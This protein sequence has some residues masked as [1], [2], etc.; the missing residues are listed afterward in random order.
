M[1]IK[2]T[3]KQLAWQ[4]A[5]P[6]AE[7]FQKP[8]KVIVPLP[9]YKLKGST[10]FVGINQKT[11]N[12]LL[13]DIFERFPLGAAVLLEHPA[14]KNA[15]QSLGVNESLTQTPLNWEW[16][17]RMRR[18]AREHE[19]VRRIMGRSAVLEFEAELHNRDM[20]V[21]LQKLRE[22]YMERQIQNS[23]E[24]TRKI[25]TASMEERDRRLERVEYNHLIWDQRKWNMF[26]LRYLKE[27]SP[28][29]VFLKDRIDQAAEPSITQRVLDKRAEISPMEILLEITD[30]L[31]HESQR[32]QIQRT[33]EQWMAQI[34]MAKV[35]IADAA[36]FKKQVEKMFLQT[37]IRDYAKG[38]VA[39]SDEKASY[40][41]LQ[42]SRGFHLDKMVDNRRDS[43]EFHL[44]GHVAAGKDREAFVQFV[45]RLN[46]RRYVSNIYNDLR[47]NHQK[48]LANIRQ[49]YP[50]TV[51]GVTDHVQKDFTKSRTQYGI[52]RAW[53]N[54]LDAK[55]EA[56]DTIVDQSIVQADAMKKLGENSLED[57]IKADSIVRTIRARDIMSQ[58]SLD[59]LTEMFAATASAAKMVAAA[60]GTENIS[61]VSSSE[62]LGKES[63]K[64]TKPIIFSATSKSA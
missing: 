33:F 50:V 8:L 11:H 35:V 18:F 19:E 21:D 29:K 63:V 44:R 1:S 58:Y 4:S 42:E 38:L 54:A 61:K 62:A 43:R 9:D 28:T 25:E 2:I 39:K 46:F 37:F 55:I 56:R 23:L 17:R 12:D 52:I 32:E 40:D 45:D 13:K 34:N 51:E 27:F 57:A 59:Q 14:F 49:F 26:L 47:E 15:I 64:A 31:F 36:V 53:V 30:R 5:D 24:N 6:L 48:H 60:H 16:H 22:F 10:D 20:L 7:E 41:S 3:D